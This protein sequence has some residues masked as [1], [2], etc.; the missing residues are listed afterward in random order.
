[1]PCS[2]L[3]DEKAL[4]QFEIEGLFVYSER[5]IELLAEDNCDPR[6]EYYYYPTEE[7]WSIGDRTITCTVEQ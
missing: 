5:E 4:S 3:W 1:M 7:S 2:G 6:Y